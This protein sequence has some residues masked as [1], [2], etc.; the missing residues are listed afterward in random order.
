VIW[1]G[2][3]IIRGPGGIIDSPLQDPIEADNLNEVLE[4]L[5]KIQ[6]PDT[7][8]VHTIGL[9]LKVKEATK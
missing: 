1:E 5:T 9:T 8:I 3:I 6:F 4:K 2:N 7:D